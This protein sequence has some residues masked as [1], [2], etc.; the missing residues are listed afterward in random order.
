M[1][2]EQKETITN[3]HEFVYSIERD[4]EV[5]LVSKRIRFSLCILNKR[6]KKE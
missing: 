2:K 5:A 3:I 1:I 6:L 4:T